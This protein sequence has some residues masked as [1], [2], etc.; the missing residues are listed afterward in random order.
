MKRLIGQWQLLG[1]AV[2]ALGGTLLH[3]LYEWLGDAVWIA[4]LSGVNESTWEHMK[5]LF[6]PM[7]LFA[8][9][10]YFLFRDRAYRE[11]LELQCVE[12]EKLP[13]VLGDRARLR[14]VFV[15]LIDNA[16]KYSRKNGSVRVDV[17]TVPNGVQVVV[18]DNGI[19]ISAKDLPNVKQKFYRANNKKPGSGIGLAV[20]EEI[21]TSHGGT[22][23][24]E[25]AEGQGTVVTVTLPACES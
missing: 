18:S 14:Q 20:A 9:V 5:L 13:P 3:F 1:F 7:L 6:W 11:G 25:S 12:Q 21:V 24:I 10:Q 19:G 22:L 4:P 8:A 15:N 2:T 16:L 23:E 17:A